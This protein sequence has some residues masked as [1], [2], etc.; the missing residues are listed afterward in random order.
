VAKLIDHQVMTHADLE[1]A[2][3]LAKQ[4]TVVPH[5]GKGAKVEDGSLHVPLP[6]Y[7]Y[8]MIRVNV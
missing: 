2:N 5:K 4:N 1:A 7:S 6:P 8:Q 3:T